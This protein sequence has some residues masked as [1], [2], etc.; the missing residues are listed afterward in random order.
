ML[1]G[2]VGKPY[3]GH[4]FE[5]L[6]DE[7][8]DKLKDVLVAWHRRLNAYASAA[9]DPQDLGYWWGERASVGMLAAAAWNLGRGYAALEE[10][11]TDRKGGPG[12]CDAWL[13]LDGFTVNVEAKQVWVANDSRA[14][15]KRV[16]D[17]IIAATGQ[18]EQLKGNVRGDLGL[19]ATFVVPSVRIYKNDTVATAYEKAEGVWSKLR[20]DFGREPRYAIDVHECSRSVFQ[21]LF[22]VASEAEENAERRV[23]PGV[24]LVLNI[25]FGWHT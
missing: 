24:G 9:N 23:Y 10:Y 16:K 22:E 18:L 12:R 25:A 3:W 21:S 5:T 20:H 2:R 8:F 1:R 14:S 6:N 19:A 4:T 7:D 13:V 11:A 15:M 17:E